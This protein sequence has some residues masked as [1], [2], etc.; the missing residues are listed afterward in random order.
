[1]DSDVISPCGWQF[2]RRFA[3]EHAGIFISPG[4]HIRILGMTDT[5]QTDAYNADLS[6]RRAA[7][8]KRNLLT[9]LGAFIG[10][11]PEDI[12]AVGLGELA[13]RNGVDPATIPALAQP[14][15]AGE[16]ALAGSEPWLVDFVTRRRQ[17]LG[18]IANDISA[19]QWRSVV[20]LLDNTVV[21]ELTDPAP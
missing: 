10:V 9:I 5:T 3:S 19:A 1:M 13:A 16:P 20:I 12:R 11:R 2:L 4:A 7:T 8:V 6:Q 18:T 17:T 21:M 15:P 14:G